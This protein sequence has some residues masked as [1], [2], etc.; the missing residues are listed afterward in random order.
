M[1]NQAHVT[2]IEVPSPLSPLPPPGRPP[3][4]LPTSS[5]YFFLRHCTNSL[6]LQE[7]RGR[8]EFFFSI[9]YSQSTLL[10]SFIFFF[11]IFFTSPFA[12]LEISR[13]N[14]M[15][16]KR[17]TESSR[18]RTSL[19]NSRERF[20]TRYIQYFRYT[21]LSRSRSHAREIAGEI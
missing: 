13:D 14:E 16:G 12:F 21:R 3:L 7:K 5:S 10:V 11:F 20:P 1:R 19:S 15:V 17:T 2:T 18:N 4:Q 9:S 6:A 8:F